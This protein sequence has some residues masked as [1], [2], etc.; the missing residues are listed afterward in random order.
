MSC[1][2]ILIRQ[3]NRMCRKREHSPTKASSQQCRA[4]QTQLTPW[5]KQSKTQTFPHFCL[6]FWFAQLPYTT[7]LQ[8]C[9]GTKIR[10]R[11][12]YLISSNHLWL[13]VFFLLSQYCLL[14]AWK[15]NLQ[16][17]ML[18]AMWIK[19]FLRSSPWSWIFYLKGS[20]QNGMTSHVY[21]WSFND[22]FIWSTD[23][24]RTRNAL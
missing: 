24:L 17:K 9:S 6:Q 15:I 18:V 19:D 20:V 2:V 21:G 3:T 12:D 11:S 1:A 4:H 8:V 22:S 16:C 10:S 7:R 5:T 13:S 14:L 23:Y